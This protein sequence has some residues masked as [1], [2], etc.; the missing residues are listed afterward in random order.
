M[1]SQVF[2]L[3]PWGSITIST[4]GSGALSV[5]SARVAADGP[6]GGV[7]RFHLPNVGTAGVGESR[8]LSG[9]LIPVRRTAGGISTGITLE[10]TAESAVTIN[11]TLR[12][13]SGVPV[14]GGTATIADLP[15]QGHVAQFIEQLFPGADTQ[16]FEG[17]VSATVGGGTVAATA[18][19]LGRNPGE[20]TTLPVTPAD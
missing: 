17:T 5:G 20:F 15:P 3:A 19:E 7:V 6:M 13:A 2:T 16:G 14:E 9:I 10:N 1:T 4:D 18:L 8:P 12:D 11:L